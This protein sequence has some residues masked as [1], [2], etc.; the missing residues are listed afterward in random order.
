[1]RYDDVFKSITKEGLPGFYKG[2]LIHIS[3]T[4]LQFFSKMK[5]IN[6]LFQKEN[7]SL[8]GID[9][10]KMYI[11]SLACNSLVDIMLQPLHMMHTRFIYQDSVKHRRI[12]ENTIKY[13]MA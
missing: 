7:S 13:F 6:F 10:R 1:M 4:F 3:Y 5:I 2:N 9:Y 12:Y 8:E 11:Y